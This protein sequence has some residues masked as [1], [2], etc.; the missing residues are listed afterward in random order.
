MMGVKEVADLYRLLENAEVKIWIDGGWA[1]D[2]LLG[3]ETR[4][5]SDLD[6]AVE[7]KDAAKLRTLLEERGYKE[8]SRDDTSEWNFVLHDG[9]G[10]V[11]VHV[12]IADEKGEVVG[13]IPYPTESLKGQG[14]ITGHTVHCISAEHM[15]KFMAE[16]VHKHPEKYMPDIAALCEKFA[17]PYPEEYE[18]LQRR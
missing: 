15:V 6:I 1:T 11:D 16:W 14:T 10:Q 2:A 17:I 18:K 9:E 12:F 13:G 3:K 8:V 7:Q 4:E 5:H